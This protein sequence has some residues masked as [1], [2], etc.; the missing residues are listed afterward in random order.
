MTKLNNGI[1]ILL[2]IIVVIGIYFCYQQYDIN[3]N[4]YGNFGEVIG[5]IF[6]SIATIFVYLTYQSQ[7]AELRE[8]KKQLKETADLTRK[9]RFEDTFFNILKV[10]QDIKNSIILNTASQIAIP[11]SS[12]YVLS[13][14]SN[15]SGNDLFSFVARDFFNLYLMP[16]CINPAGKMV[17]RDVFAGLLDEV[18]V[19][20]PEKRIKSRYKRFFDNYHG[21]MGHYFRHLFHVLKF[22][23]DNEDEEVN[24]NS[25][26]REAVQKKYKFYAGVVQA[27]MGSSELF[28]LFYNAICFSRM[29]ELVEHYSMVE[30][31]FAE[32]LI[33]PG[34]HHNLLKNN[35]LKTRN[36][37]ID[38]LQKGL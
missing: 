11:Q 22:I 4:K 21:V 13:E 6:A 38:A 35:Q 33:D 2:M 34:R 20:Q 24:L 17:L 32:D 14:S 37:I 15:V 36:S 18:P 3:A 1:L 10:Q 7:K 29:R 5:A 9:Q 25:D 28:M 27:Q 30:N 16:E 26:A 31:L 8:Q 23:K 12:Q 19:D